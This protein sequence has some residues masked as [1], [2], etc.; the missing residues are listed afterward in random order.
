MNQK[1]LDHVCGFCNVL[2]PVDKNGEVAPSSHLDVAALQDK[3]QKERSKKDQ[4]QVLMQAVISK[5][6]QKE[7]MR[8]GMQ[9]LT[10]IGVM[11]SESLM[12]L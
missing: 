3:G 10:A 6:S 9:R 4:K 1:I 7:G 2:C 11:K 8:L 5:L 12:M